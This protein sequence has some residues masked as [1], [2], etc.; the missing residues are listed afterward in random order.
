MESEQKR[1]HKEIRSLTNKGSSMRK[2]NTALGEDN[3][4]LKQE[5]TILI[6]MRKDGK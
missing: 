4:S 2:E 6:K 5:N 3:F 1:N